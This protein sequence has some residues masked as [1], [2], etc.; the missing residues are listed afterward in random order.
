MNPLIMELLPLAGQGY[1]CSQILGLLFLGDRENPLFIRALS[2]LCHGLG[3]SGELCG[4]LTGGCCILGAC[5]G[6]GGPPDAVEA[7]TDAGLLVN[8]Y[9]EWFRERNPGGCGCPAIMEATCGRCGAPD[10]ARCGE[11]LA[12]CWGKILEILEEAGIDPT[13]VC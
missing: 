1:C 11:L 3:Q 6:K 8:T 10:M 4:L 5:S 9:V 12:E 13:D 2:G 7:R